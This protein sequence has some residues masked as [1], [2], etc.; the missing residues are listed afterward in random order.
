VEARRI[1]PYEVVDKL[2]A[3]GMGTV[4][5][6]QDTRTG[7]TV[8]LKVLH[9]HLGDDPDYVRRFQREAEIAKKLESPFIVRVLDSGQ[10]GSQHYL[11]MEHVEGKN[12]AQVLQERRKLPPEEARA[13]AIQVALALEVAHQKGVVHRDIKPGNILIT[14]ENAAKVT[15]FGIARAFDSTTITKT[16]VFLGTLTYA[17]PELLAGNADIRSDIYSLGVVLYQMLAV[18]VPFEADTPLEL[19]EMHRSQRPPSLERL[20][21]RVPADLRAIVTRCLAK[22]PQKRYQTPS[23]LLPALQGRPVPGVAVVPAGAAGD[24]APPITP[25]RKWSGSDWFGGRRLRYA[26]LGAG[27]AGV[28]LAALLVAVAMAGGWSSRTRNEEA[29]VTVPDATS[30]QRP[31]A[32]LATAALPTPVLTP[33]TTDRQNCPDGFF[34]ERMSGQCCVQDRSL[35]PPH[36][37]IGYTG[38]SLCEDGWFEVYGRRP[39]TDGN[40][41]PGCP[42]YNSFVF[43]LECAD[44]PE[45]A[46]QRQAE[47]D[48]SGGN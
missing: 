28:V 45:A 20:G 15:D 3:G 35:L 7:Q 27:I 8:A 44:S 29:G 38:N 17:A 48:A 39:T 23:E 2:G 4:Y 1:G 37:K 14:E 47:I 43:L 41:P 25:T 24:E 46:Q 16:G 22:R 42:G 10:D 32:P 13:I 31:L 6:A 36:G 11:V 21:V 18:R 30:T 9:P 19:I 34:W 12:L 5:R 26:L 40:G 33:R